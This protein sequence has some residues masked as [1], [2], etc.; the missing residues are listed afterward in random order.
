MK[1]E[2]GKEKTA[3]IKKKR[4]GFLYGRGSCELREA[5]WLMWLGRWSQQKRESWDNAGLQANR[6]SAKWTKKDPAAKTT[7]YNKAY[8]FITC[9]RESYELEGLSK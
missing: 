3:W 2:R 1:R 9:W 4:L 6:S 5:D 7:T 8:F